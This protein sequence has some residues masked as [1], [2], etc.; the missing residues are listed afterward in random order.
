MGLVILG[1]FSNRLAER[2][3]SC[4]LFHKQFPTRLSHQRFDKKTANCCQFA[5]LNLFGELNSLGRD[6]FHEVND[7]VAVTPFVVIPAYNLEEAFFALQIIL[8]GC[9]AVVD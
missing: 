7:A 2:P 8:Q 6:V 5:V 3:T 4:E 9:K 1:S